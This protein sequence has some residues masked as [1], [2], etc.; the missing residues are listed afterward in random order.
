MCLQSI[1]VCLCS[2]CDIHFLCFSHYSELLLDCLVHVACTT[3]RTKQ[4]E[5]AGERKTGK[6]T[7]QTC[8]KPTLAVQFSGRQAMLRFCLWIPICSLHL[9]LN[10]SLLFSGSVWVSA[11]AFQLKRSLHH[12]FS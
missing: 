1:Q 10:C 11:C 2:H 6:C 9:S 7:T 8:L 4:T 12:I 5:I 3:Q